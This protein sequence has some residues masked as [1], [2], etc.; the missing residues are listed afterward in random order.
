M[1]PLQHFIPIQSTPRVQQH[2]ARRLPATDSIW[3]NSLRT[4]L[5]PR[6]VVLV[7]RSQQSMPI[8]SQAIDDHA[9]GSI[10]TSPVVLESEQLARS[11]HNSAASASHALASQRIEQL[12]NAPDAPVI[13][14]IANRANASDISSAT[15]ADAASAPRANRANA[16]SAADAGSEPG[17]VNLLQNQSRSSRI[18]AWSASRASRSR[19]PPSAGS[20]GSEHLPN[21]HEIDESRE[22]VRDFTSSYAQTQESPDDA[23]QL[24]Q[25]L[26][27]TR[28]FA[29]RAA[30]EHS[31]RSPQSHI[32]SSPSSGPNTPPSERESLQFH[33]IGDSATNPSI[34]TTPQLGSFRIISRIGSSQHIPESPTHE[35]EHNGNTFFSRLQR[36]AA[37]SLDAD[38]NP[39]GALNARALFDHTPVPS[40]AQSN[41]NAPLGPQSDNI[42]DPAS[43]IGDIVARTAEFEPGQNASTTLVPNYAAA[44][45][46]AHSLSRQNATAGAASSVSGSAAAAATTDGGI[47]AASSSAAAGATNRSSFYRH[48]DADQAGAASI[49][50]T[51]TRAPNIHSINETRS[52][53]PATLNRVPILPQWRNSKTNEE[54]KQAMRSLMECSICRELV[55]EQMIE[56]PCGQHMCCLHCAIQWS[57]RLLQYQH[58]IPMSNSR[59]CMPDTMPIIR[60]LH[61]FACR[62]SGKFAFHTDTL[63]FVDLSLCKA[64]AQMLHIRSFVCP[65]CDHLKFCSL[66]EA[67]C[68]IAKCWHTWWPCTRLNSQEKPCGAEHIANAREHSM[69]H[70][71]T[72]SCIHCLYHL[73][74]GVCVDVPLSRVIKHFQSRE[75]HTISP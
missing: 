6:R 73:P 66:E 56:F 30:S 9:A 62:T 41:L 75:P 54:C 25:R 18:V 14:P 68:H 33:D 45:S 20:R 21:I 63:R 69:H 26:V 39:S 70:C 53:E 19:S 32:P 8:L 42:V 52:R 27:P 50:V 12:S 49:L 35:F 23:S 71:N 72:Y 5:M 16:A 7:Q 24:V 22:S 43:S 28:L 38:G 65:H 51:P 2:Y 46:A 29:E 47:S 17:T 11:G 31:G 60:H 55:L 1:A 67:R 37:I 3:R 64:I 36:A 13:T 74:Q 44:I 34:S 48:S 61:C 15:T 4:S 10:A 58:S 59:P 40:T 57:S